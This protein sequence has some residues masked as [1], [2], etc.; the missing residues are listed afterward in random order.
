MSV[1]E[2]RRRDGICFGAFAWIAQGIFVGWLCVMVLRLG[3]LLGQLGGFMGQ[4]EHLC[5]RRDT[6]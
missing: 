4:V 5:D 6:G 1:E 3:I 2:Y